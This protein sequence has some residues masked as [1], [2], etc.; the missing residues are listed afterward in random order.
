MNLTVKSKLLLESMHVKIVRKVTILT[1]RQLNAKIQLRKDMQLEFMIKKVDMLTQFLTVALK[2]NLKQSIFM[3]HP[4][5][6][7][8]VQ[9]SFQTVINAHHL[10]LV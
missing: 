6:A 1:D 5:N 2:K 3:T 8:Y 7:F 10:T 4:M 9:M